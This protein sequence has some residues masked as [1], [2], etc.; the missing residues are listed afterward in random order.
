MF[1]V[2]LKLGMFDKLSSLVK[3]LHKRNDYVSI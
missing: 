2:I 1:L 3:L